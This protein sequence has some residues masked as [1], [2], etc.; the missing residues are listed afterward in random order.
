MICKKSLNELWD[1]TKTVSQISMTKEQKRGISIPYNNGG[2]IVPK[3][4][5]TKENYEGLLT[6]NYGH[7]PEHLRDQ[8]SLNYYFE[9]QIE[10]IDS[11]YAQI[12]SELD[13][14]KWDD[15]LLLHYIHKPTVAYSIGKLNEIDKRLYP[16]WCKYAE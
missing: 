10:E 12:V 11:K 15:I 1:Y 4:F 5:L 13:S 2:M 7:K 14:D 6:S 16:L 8:K 3:K 9:G